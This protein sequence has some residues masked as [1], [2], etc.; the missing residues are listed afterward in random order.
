MKG[1][2][3]KVRQTSFRTDGSIF[4]NLNRD[5][6]ALVL[7]WECF[8]VRKRIGNTAP[9]MPLVI[10]QLRDSQFPADPFTSHPSLLTPS[11]LV[12]SPTLDLFFPNDCGGSPRG[13]SSRGTLHTV[14]LFARRRRDRGS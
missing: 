13:T 6:I 10:P 8:D 9:C 1:D 14:P 4:R 12:S 5:L 3:S 7:V 11:R 2:R